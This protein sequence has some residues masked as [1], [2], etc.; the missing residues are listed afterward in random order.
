MPTTISDLC[1]FLEAFAPPH[2]AE[3]WDNVGL[4]VGDP[5]GPVRRVM[6]CL[7]LTGGTAAEAV[8]ERADLVVTHHPL[9]FKPLKRITSESTPGRLLLELIRGGVAVYSPHTAFD[10]AADGI[11]QHLALKLG[12]VEIQPLVPSQRDVSGLGAGRYGRLLAAASLADFAKQIKQSLGASHLQ[13]VGQ[14]NR[15]VQRVAVACGSAGSFL[16]A[17]REAGCDLLVTGETNLHTCYEARAQRMSLILAGHYATE[18]F[19]LDYLAGVLQKQFADLT[20]WASRDEDDP[21]AWL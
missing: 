5:A 12:L 15:P 8:R 11:N 14:L 4:L 13:V 3:E 16:D 7:T 18:R 19:H 21:V 2:L 1:R 10:S 6:T 17:A 9:P 20:V